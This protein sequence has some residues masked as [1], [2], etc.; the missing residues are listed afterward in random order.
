M[1]SKYICVCYDA[2]NDDDD[3]NDNAN[4]AH[5]SY[6]HLNQLE[7]HETFVKKTTEY[8]RKRNKGRRIEWYWKDMKILDVSE[9]V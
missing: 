2:T 5:L 9:G 7:L 1:L 8:A 3:N 6:I 4:E